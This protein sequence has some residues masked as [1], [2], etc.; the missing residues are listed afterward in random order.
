MIH[1]FEMFGETSEEQLHTFRGIFVVRERILLAFT[2]HFKSLLYCI[3]LARSFDQR[4][5]VAEFKIFN[6]KKNRKKEYQ[7]EMILVAEHV[8]I[9]RHVLLRRLHVG[10]RRH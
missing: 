9:I 3:V 1:F 2:P 6:K 4:I 5:T 7:N 10:C 8:L